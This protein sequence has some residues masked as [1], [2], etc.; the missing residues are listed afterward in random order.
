[1]ELPPGADPLTTTTT[2]QAGG[3]IDGW[4]EAFAAG[5]AA[6]AVAAEERDGAG[7][8]RLALRV[9]ASAAAAIARG[10]LDVRVQLHRTASYPVVT[11]TV[12]APA[13]IRTGGPHAVTATLDVNADVDRKALGVLARRFALTVELVAE[14]RRLRRAVLVAPLEE[15]VAYLVRAA[16]DHLRTLGA[17]PGAQP[18]YPR[19]R[20]LL[21]APGHD[22]L[23]NEHPEAA[24]FREDKLGQLAT[25]NQVRRALSIARRFSRPSREDYLVTV[26]GFPLTRWHER[27]RT[28]LA[29]AVEWGLWMGPELAQVAVSE[30]LA[31]S[32]KDLCA[33]LEPAFATLLGDA[34]AN[35]LDSDAAEDNRKALAEEARA[36]GIGRA[37]AARTVASEGEP[38]ASGTIESRS[39]T[40]D[41]RGRPVD[42]LLALLDDRGARAA[43]ALELCE[44]ADPRAIRP[45][46]NAVRRMGR[47]EAVR[48]L[49]AMVKF[50]EPAAPALT[51]GLGSSKAFLRHGCALALGMLRTEAGT[52]AVIDLLLAEPTEIWREL[53][54]G[55][56]QVGPT[57]LMPLAAR[58]GRL[59]ERASTSTK[60]RVAWAMAHV[61]V[62]GG[63]AAVEQ[64]STGQSVVAPVALQ[65]LELMA[66]AARD[67]LR[68]T[69]SGREV[70]VN[71]AFSRRFFEALGHG[72]LAAAARTELDALD[73]SSPMELLDESDLIDLD[74]DEADDEAE[75]DEA[76][77]IET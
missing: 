47:A 69:G 42:E 20:A 37:D 17:E 5:N 43:A 39:A 49:G 21:T 68:G 18:S 58:L 24:E 2:D 41:P 57:S 50:G 19:G 23:G 10:P 29:R 31:R 35:D 30:G 77:L 32:K 72:G 71:R 26:R 63:R 76:D 56:G 53:A 52:E 59:G 45:V 64:L 61:G 13:A 22:V 14:G 12:G 54:R 7:V 1:M 48:V 16:H 66:P 74:G 9:G 67:D 46:L 51:A 60:E 28:V 11:L 27:R 4:L 55:V 8:V 33:R 75:L 3:A 40:V 73:A 34:A 25:A 6:S 62:R 65:A 15:N 38:V 70:T 44:R 36:F